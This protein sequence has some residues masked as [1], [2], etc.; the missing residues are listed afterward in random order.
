MEEAKRRFPLSVFE[1]VLLA[2]VIPIVFCYFAKLS[3]RILNSPNMPS[4]FFGP[5]GLLIVLGFDVVWILLIKFLFKTHIKIKIILML[6][7]VTLSTA[8]LCWWIAGVTGI[9][10]PW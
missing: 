1:I 6:L 3:F 9:M 4:W 5:V 2:I 8:I 7:G 10:N